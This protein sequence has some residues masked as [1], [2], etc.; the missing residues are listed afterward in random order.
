[1][2][3]FQNIPNK[4]KIGSTGSAP[5]LLLLLREMATAPSVSVSILPPSLRTNQEQNLR[6]TVC[7]RSQSPRCLCC[8][9][10]CS[11]EVVIK[12]EGEEHGEDLQRQGSG[13]PRARTSLGLGRRAE[14]ASSCGRCVPMGPHAAVPVLRRGHPN[15]PGLQSAC[16]ASLPWPRGAK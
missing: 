12:A 3:T 7:R 6:N 8:A 16:C 5:D 13:S 4:S 15:L 9:S 10:S 1:M 2:W 11:V 14:G